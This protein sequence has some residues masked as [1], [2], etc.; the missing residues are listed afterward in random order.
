M[1]KIIVSIL[2]FV[3]SSNSFGANYTNITSQYAL[4]PSMKDCQIYYLRGGGFNYSSLY[5]IQCPNS[6]VDTEFPS[7]KS[8]I[9]V[10]SSKKKPVTVEINGETYMKLE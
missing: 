4:P 8:Q 5:T 9:S 7:G 3:F 10:S 6:T 2:F 1:K